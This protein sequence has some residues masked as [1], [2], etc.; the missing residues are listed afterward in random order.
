M[1]VRNINTVFCDGACAGN[2]YMQNKG[3][4][5]VVIITDE[6]ICEYSGSEINTTNQRMELIACIKALEILNNSKNL[7]EIYSDSAYLINCM[8]QK[9]YHKWLINGWKTSNKKPVENKDLWL[10]LIKLVRTK[11]IAFHKV[12]GH[13]GDKW[14]DR[15]DLLAKQAAS[16]YNKSA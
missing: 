7:I 8:N 6:T 12:T 9:W 3:G 10:D 15:A 4:W 11:K 1:T 14:N 16:S 5:G 2:Q 13:T